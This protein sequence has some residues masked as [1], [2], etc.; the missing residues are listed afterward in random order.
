MKI[1]SWNVNGIRAIS[2]KGFAEWLKSSD[3][4]V[5][6]VQE[7][8]AS[9]EQLD[10]KITTIPG[11]TSYFKSAE[12]KGYSGVAVYTKVKPENVATLGIQE[13][14]SEGRTIMVEFPNLTVISAYFPNSGDG[15]K[16]LGYK[17][18]FCKAMLEYCV[19][20]CSEKK[21]FVLCG[22]YNIAHK[23]IDLAR[24]ED[25][26][27]SAGYLPEERA[28]MDT[29][30]S[31]GFIDTF[32][33]F[34]KAPENYTWWSYVTRARERNVGWRLDYHCIPEAVAERVRGAAILSDVMGSDH[35]PVTVEIT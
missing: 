2:K 5:V 12:K 6:C 9:V 29:F 10:D 13:F 31:S 14:D 26:E 27:G 16:R 18:D 11:Y 3:A 23:P 22:D 4:D 20:L 25:N 7:T 1:V 28:W 8:K 17:L 32:R 21:P 19:R 24:P 35:C 15:S 30:L 33:M 34:N